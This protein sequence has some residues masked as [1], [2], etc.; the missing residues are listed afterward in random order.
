MWYMVCSLLVLGL[1]AAT[2]NLRED[3][4]RKRRSGAEHEATVEPETD[5]VPAGCCG[6][7]AV[8]GRDRLPAT[9]GDE[10]E[11]YDDEELDAYRG[12]PSDAYPEKAE[13]AFR[14]V[15]YTLQESEVAAWLHSLQLRGVHLPDTLKDE[16]FLIVGEQRIR[17][18]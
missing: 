18:H 12:T 16:A 2:I 11:Y 15:L 1:F 5:V 4:K 7:H 9:A 13:E 6:Q 8:C 17:Q 3:R 14:N 10:I